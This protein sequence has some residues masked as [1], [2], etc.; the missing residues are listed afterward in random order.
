MA[1]GLRMYRARDAIGNV[2][3]ISKIER[4]DLVWCECCHVKLVY[5]SGYNRG[6][7]ASGPIWVQSY[8]RL[9]LGP[10]MI[11]IANTL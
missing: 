4:H 5:N 3:P 7:G 11:P 10:S 2:V 8:L 1:K 9:P 6:A